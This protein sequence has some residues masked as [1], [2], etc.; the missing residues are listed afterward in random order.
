MNFL[1]CPHCRTHVAV[2]EGGDCPS[3]RN[4][5]SGIRSAPAHSD[6]D[7]VSQAA[8]PSQ[9]NPYSVSGKLNDAIATEQITTKQ[10]RLSLRGILTSICSLIGLLSGVVGMAC[11]LPALI[12]PPTSEDGYPI[13]KVGLTLGWFTVGASAMWWLAGMLCW[14]RRWWIALAVALIA[15][16]LLATASDFARR[17][18]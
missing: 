2:H 9:L 8:T 18:V 14:K 15:I 12:G 16:L 6:D 11:F 4:P 5:R 7:R 3:C 10:G 13:A 1:T 17:Y